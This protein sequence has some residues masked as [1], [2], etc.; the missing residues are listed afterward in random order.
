MVPKRLSLTRSGHFTVVD[1]R[2]S[3]LFIR[4]DASSVSFSDP[5]HTRLPQQRRPTDFRFLAMATN[6]YEFRNQLFLNNRTPF[7]T[8]SDKTV[9]TPQPPYSPDTVPCELFLVPKIKRTLKD[10]RCT[11]IDDVK[12]VSLKKLRAIPKIEFGKCFWELEGTLVQ[13]H[14]I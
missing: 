8:A 6:S 7:I 3:F 5:P 1:S 4:S 11:S 10:R 12:S 2:T 13:M 9:T 14:N